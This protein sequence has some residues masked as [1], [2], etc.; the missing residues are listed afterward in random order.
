MAFRSSSISRDHRVANTSQR[1]SENFPA[2]SD[3]GLG[4]S[5][6]FAEGDNEPTGEEIGDCSDNIFGAGNEF[7]SWLNE[8]IVAG[9]VADQ[10]D[11]DCHAVSTEPHCRRNRA[12]ESDERESVAQERL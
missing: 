9:Y 7:A 1:Y 10:G 3:P 12:E 4:Y 5:R 11:R 2:I 6:C 8:Q